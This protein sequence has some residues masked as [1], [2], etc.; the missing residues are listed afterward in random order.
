[1]NEV[2]SAARVLDILELLSMDGGAMRLSDVAQSLGLP[3]SSAHGLLQTLVGRGYVE[4]TEE[5]RYQLAPEFRG[6]SSW[7]GGHDA[8]L[9]HHALPVMRR[10]RD[11]CGETLFLGVLGPDDVV[12]HVCKALSD[13]PIRYDNTGR[14]APP[15]YCS[16]MGRVLLAHAEPARID[17]YFA[18]TVLAPVT[19]RTLTDEAAIRAVL[20]EIRARGYGTIEEEYAIGGCGVAAPVRNRSGAVIAVLDVATVAQRYAERRDEMIQTVLAAS[21]ELSARLGYSAAEVA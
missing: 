11:A 4:R 10:A 18:R 14:P 16:V 21:A 5:E 9:R 7:V 13:H 12:R 1:M 17:A 20:G 15:L 2:K 19:P 3:R 8:L 6:G